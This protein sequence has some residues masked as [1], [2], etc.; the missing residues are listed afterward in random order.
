[1]LQFAYC[2][3]RGAKGRF[4]LKARTGIGVSGAA[5]FVQPFDPK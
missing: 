1:M 3:L 2:F 4:A 5:I